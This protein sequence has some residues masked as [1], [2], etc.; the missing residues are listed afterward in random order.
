M[1]VDSD[2]GLKRAVRH[3]VDD[4]M[5][6]GHGVQNIG[7]LCGPDGNAEATQ[8]FEAFRSAAIEAGVYNEQFVVKNG[9][10]TFRWGYQVMQRLLGEWRS[11][12]A[13]MAANDEMARGALC[14]WEEFFRNERQPAIIGFDGTDLA[15]GTMPPLTTIRQ[16]IEEQGRLAAETLLASF[17]GN[18]TAVKLPPLRAELQLRESCGCST[19]DSTEPEPQ[20]DHRLGVAHRGLTGPK[21]THLVRKLV[22]SAAHRARDTEAPHFP[23]SDISARALA[24]L[25]TRLQDAP[26]DIPVWQEALLHLRYG[27]RQW[28]MRSNPA[29]DALDALCDELTNRLNR[30]GATLATKS[31]DQRHAL[32]HLRDLVGH[33]EAHVASETAATLPQLGVFH[34]WVC[35]HKEQDDHFVASGTEVLERLKHFLLDGRARATLA[36]R[37]GHVSV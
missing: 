29:R 22:V 20:S 19:L 28:L 9:D 8:R 33:D 3:L 35:C 32:A 5:A 13:I 34:Y 18:A 24:L 6:G 37:S 1:V 23:L 17:R 2:G 14:A 27:A 21:A 25:D 12:Q 30:K 4:A 7:F 26:T 15:E 11:V 10:F 31:A 36:V 16:P